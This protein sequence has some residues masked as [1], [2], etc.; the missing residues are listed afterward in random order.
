[1]CYSAFAATVIDNI[2]QLLAARA[3][4]ILG[5]SVALPHVTRLSSP[6]QLTARH[7]LLLIH[8]SVQQL[9]RGLNSHE[10]HTFTIS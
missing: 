3:E 7:E 10:S 5:L 2:A 4:I 6:Q 1:M 8:C 9:W